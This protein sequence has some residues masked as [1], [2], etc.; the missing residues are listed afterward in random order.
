[1]L[2]CDLLEANEVLTMSNFAHETIHTICC[3]TPW[4]V[5]QAAISFIAKQLRN[6]VE[7]KVT[8][9]KSDPMLQDFLLQPL[10]TFPKMRRLP[11]KIASEICRRECAAK[12]QVPS[13]RPP[14]IP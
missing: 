8:A 1:M 2:R 7:E 4:A 6:E 9:K 12:V 10:L 13:L 3:S 11:G 5:T 14:S